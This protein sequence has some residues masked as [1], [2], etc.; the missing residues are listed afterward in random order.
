MTMKKSYLLY[1][2]G[3]RLTFFRALSALFPRAQAIFL[4]GDAFDEGQWVDD[5]EWKEY[6]R[7]FRSMF[8]RSDSVPMIVVPGNHDIGFHY[9]LINHPC[10]LTTVTVL[11]FERGRY[12]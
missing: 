11:T 5:Q 4:L 10:T 7:R 8:R 9:H 1:P 2:R 12:L 3:T 6:L